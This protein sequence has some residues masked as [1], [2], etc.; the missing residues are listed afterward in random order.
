MNRDFAHRGH[1]SRAGSA[2]KIQQRGFDQ[3]IS[4]MSEKDP[5]ATAVAG[6]LDKKSKAR[7]TAGGLNRQ[8][9]SPGQSADISRPN[10]AVQFKIARDLLDKAGIAARGR[11]AQLMIKMA[12][13][14][15]LVVVRNEQM[16]QRDGIA[17]ARNADEVAVGW[18]EVAQ[19]SF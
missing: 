9:R 15:I 10:L 8:L 2:K 7:E 6:D 12:N 11:A 3:I 5:A 17:A 13:D 1:A 19:E 14:E 4:M 18:R 16:Q